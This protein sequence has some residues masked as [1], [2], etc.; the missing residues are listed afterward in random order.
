MKTVVASAQ[1]RRP[2]RYCVPVPVFRS[3]NLMCMYGE[4]VY[5]FGTFYYFSWAP[6]T[7]YFPPLVES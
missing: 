2:A 5:H 6:P 1:A 4:N 3:N 7:L